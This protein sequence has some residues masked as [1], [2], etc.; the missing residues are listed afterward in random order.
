MNRCPAETFIRDNV[1]QNYQ[2][3]HAVGHYGAHKNKHI[4]WTDADMVWDYDKED[5]RSLAGT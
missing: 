3:V 5:Y 2:C 4:T 1:H